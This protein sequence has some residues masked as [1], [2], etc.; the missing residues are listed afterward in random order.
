MYKGNEEDTI[1]TLFPLPL[2]DMRMHTQKLDQEQDQDVKHP[3]G[4]KEEP[5]DGKLDLCM[6]LQPP[7]LVSSCQHGSSTGTYTTAAAASSV[8]SQ[9]ASH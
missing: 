2:F 4:H 3:S 9:E 5:H 1:L 8:P 7:P 6:H